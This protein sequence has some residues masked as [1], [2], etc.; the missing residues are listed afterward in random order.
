[1]FA[2]SEKVHAEGA[3]FYYN[4]GLQQAK[5]GNFFESNL[6]Y[7]KAIKI[8]PQYAD[9]YYQM[10]WNNLRMRDYSGAISSY[11]EFVRLNP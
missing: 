7:S 1:M 6:D 9:A 10:A 5:S 4:R 3:A 8:N 2:L 11:L